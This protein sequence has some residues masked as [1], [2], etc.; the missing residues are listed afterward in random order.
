MQK[1]V[2]AWM[3]FTAMAA[4]SLCAQEKP[5]QSAET[6]A[7]DQKKILSAE[8][9]LELRSVQDPQ[10]SPDGSRVAF[11]VSEPLKGEKRI[12]HI[13]L[14][15]K[16]SGAARQLTFSEKSETWPRWSPDG[17]KL[18]FL[19]N[20]GGDEQQIY[21]MSMTGG[22]AAPVTKGK[23]SVRAFEWPPSGQS[24]AHMR[25]DPKSEAEEKKIKEKDDARGVDKDDKH[26]RPAIPEPG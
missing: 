16:K 13:W 14:S 12:R 24:I 3:M 22:E 2:A 1:H 25:P 20:R 11:V 17:K 8:S 4:G 10:F 21:I 15:D 26:A 18:A 6:R 19:S 7:A 5:A 9:F 23:A